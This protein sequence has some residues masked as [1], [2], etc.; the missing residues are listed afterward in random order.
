MRSERLS[1]LALAVLKGYCA[2]L[3]TGRVKGSQYWFADMGDLI[4]VA[5]D[6]DMCKAIDT[7]AA[8]LVHLRTLVYK[9]ERLKI[10]RDPDHGIPFAAYVKATT[11]GGVERVVSETFD[12]LCRQVSTIR[13]A[14]F[15]ALYMSA[16]TSTS[17]ST[18][19]LDGLVLIQEAVNKAV[20][21]REK[22]HLRELEVIRRMKHEYDQ[23]LQATSGMR[24]EL[25][26]ARNALAAI[27]GNDD[28][29]APTNN[30]VTQALCAFNEVQSREAVEDEP[31]SRAELV[32]ALTAAGEHAVARDA[33]AELTKLLASGECK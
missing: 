6:T 1:A 3:K 25:A 20:T 31:I 19:E 16:T 7:A 32:R 12:D 5:L 4:V 2:D 11:T 29:S 27:A 24:E 14:A 23:L 13:N 8:Q 9:V 33:I 30:L 28:L 17:T 26:R 18:T 10:T 21:R 15:G 22:A